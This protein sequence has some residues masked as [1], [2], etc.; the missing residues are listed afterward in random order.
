[1]TDNNDFA[2]GPRFV[3][4]ATAKDIMRSMHLVSTI[5]G[6]GMTMISGAPGVGKTCTILN[7]IEGNADVIHITA[8]KG[9]GHAYAQAEN[10]LGY[11]NQVSKSRSLTKLRLH[12]IEE[13][14]ERDLTLIVDESQYLNEEGIEWL[15]AL[16]ESALVNLILV[17]DLKLRVLI[18]GIPQLQSRM[19]RPVIIPSV[20]KRDVSDLARA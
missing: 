15:R 1:M 16:C 19:C 10:L 7:F 12:L 8:A 14:Q 6:A 11:F 4:T 3:P 20:K 9:E 5:N 18:E 17:G 13:L 2:K